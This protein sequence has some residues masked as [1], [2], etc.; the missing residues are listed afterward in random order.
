MPKLIR[1]E[2]PEYDPKE[3]QRH[4]ECVKIVLEIIIDSSKLSVLGTIIDE[5]NHVKH[6]TAIHYLYESIIENIKKLYEN[7]CQISSDF[8]DEETITN[9]TEHI[10]D[11]DYDY[12]GELG[13]QLINHFSNMLLSK[14]I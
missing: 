13:T 8:L 12:A 3:E 6:T 2:Q 4:D 10:G 7:E 11:L 1:I 14:H 9:I 5:S